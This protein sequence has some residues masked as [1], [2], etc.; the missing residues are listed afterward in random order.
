MDNL[1]PL[2]R[3]AISRPGL[4]GR[5]GTLSTAALGVAILFSLI[6]APVRADEPLSARID[7]L[8]LAATP[9]AA[10]IVAPIADDA[11]FLRRVSLDLI[12]TIPTAIQTREF[13]ADQ[14]PNKRA[15]LVDRLLAS[16][17][18]ARHMQK[19]F[20][21][22]L[23]QRR[24]AQHVGASEWQ[25]Y[26]RTS[27][28]ENK[29]W[30]QL[31]RE[32]LGQDGTDPKTRAAARFFLDRDVEVNLVTRDIGRIFLGVNL[33]CAQCHDHPQ[34]DDFKQQHYYGLSAFLV[35]SS[36]FKKGNDPAL[37]AEKADGEVTFESVFDI[38]DKK[39][40]GPKSTPPRLFEGVALTDPMLEKGKEY[41]VKPEKDVRP[42]PAYSRRSLLGTAI[43]S[44]EN[45]RFP[46]ALANRLWGLMLGRGLIEPLEYDHSDNP[47][48]I[49]A[50]LDLLT[51]EVVARKYD[52]KSMLREIALSQTYQRS[53]RRKPDT[54]EPDAGKFLVAQLKPL[55]PEQFAQ[56]LMQ[57]S[58]LT[59]AERAALGDKATEEALSARLAGAEG[60]LV[61]LFGSEPGRIERGFDA[62]ADQALFLAHNGMVLG[63]IVPRPGNLCDRM[64]KMSADQ[65]AAI[66]DELYLS[67]LSRKPDA[68]ETQ[69]VVNY[70]APRTADRTQAIMELIWASTM[71]AE[72]RFNH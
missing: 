47:P 45:K 21:V 35:R 22:I 56:A 68:E 60:V 54:A 33:E 36:L 43:V 14:N 23:M 62:R 26:L 63:W 34:I 3:L 5:N 51:Q 53:S 30:D 41:T 7:Q 40:T 48:S 58:G 10:T 57:A 1:L 64:S 11:E 46:R 12:G 13:L 18:Y 42:V 29:P 6:S 70:L 71:S 19:T 20:D 44:P 24:P 9:D 32:I 49:P 52:I 28:A 37:L 65:P 72:F 69:D 31:V 66:A 61:N 55:S 59:D 38:R 2:P 27:F 39:S 67:V 25:T 17:E 4:S 8:V 16:P 50:L 15:T